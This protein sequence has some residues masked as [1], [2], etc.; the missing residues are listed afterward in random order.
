MRQNPLA[1]LLT[2]AGFNIG[3]FCYQV[4]NTNIEILKGLKQDPT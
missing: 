1:I 2:T 3:G 4:R